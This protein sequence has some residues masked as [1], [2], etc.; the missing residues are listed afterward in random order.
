MSCKNGQALVHSSFTLSPAVITTTAAVLTL[1]AVEEKRQNI[2]T[3]VKWGCNVHLEGSDY[4]C[5]DI[6]L[7][8]TTILYR[9]KK[10]A[11]GKRSK[12]QSSTQLIHSNLTKSKKIPGNDLRDFRDFTNV[13][14]QHEY[15]RRE[16][17]QASLLCTY[18]IGMYVCF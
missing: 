9:R 14:P 13:N 7:V 3:D 8:G 10:Q 17:K 11:M 2:Q 4:V 16:L 1:I 15:G 18:V 5:S 12:N 6:W